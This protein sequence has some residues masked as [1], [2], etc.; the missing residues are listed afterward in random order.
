MPQ[1]PFVGREFE[2][3]RLQGLTKKRS[4]SLVVVRGRRGI[5]KSRL[6]AEFG[7][8]MKSFFFTGT[9]PSPQVT[10]QLQRE[11]FVRQL[12]RAGIPGITPDD[13]GN[14]FWH[15]SKYTENG[16]VLIVLDE[17]SWMGSKDSEFLGKLKNCWDM[18]FSKNSELIIILCGPIFSWIED[19]ILNN[20]GFRGRI[21]LDLIL[22]E[23]PL[24]ICNAFWDLREK[25]I[26]TYEKFKLLS[27]TGGI[28]L[29][30]EQMNPH[31]S[32]EQN[33]YN[34]SFTK[35]GFFVKEFEKLFSDISS[36]SMA[37]YRDIIHCLV[38]EPKEL[39]LICQEL[40]KH[41]G[42][43][44]STHLDKLVKAGF[45]QRDFSW[46]LKSKKPSKLS[47]YRLSDNYLRFYLKYIAPNQE[48]IDQGESA[49]R[50]LA[51]LTKLEDIMGLQLENLVLHN[52]Q[53][54][55][56]LMGIPV[57]EIVMEGP[58]FQNATVRQKSSQISYMVQTRF[59]TLYICEI[60]F[61][62]NTLGT[63]V[64]QDLKE[65]INRLKIP[66]RFSIRPVLIH[67]NGAQDSVL[68]QEYFYKTID[69][70]EFLT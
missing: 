31:L 46:D 68:D 21:T 42:G 18:Y 43:R 19:N 52:R 45:V 62:K 39:T 58:F 4:A 70:S 12:A 67:V 24:N 49:N 17:I 25:H 41:Q 36:R 2:I 32:V 7:K 60:K 29:Y 44:Y 6:C 23:I 9:H 57:E 11:E 28:L 15:L 38:D 53:I 20:T 59:N 61:S 47:R 63:S 34:L 1:S 13:W 48:K 50:L 35:E 30:L 10:A 56:K 33:I 22:E 51:H 65:K 66:K 3:K 5:G 27:I 37:T 40:E 8:E 26:S 64:I 54:L 16:R 14:M 55:W 69:F